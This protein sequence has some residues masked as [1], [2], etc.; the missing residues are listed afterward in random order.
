MAVTRFIT[1]GRGVRSGAVGSEGGG[2]EQSQAEPPQA[3]QPQ[4]PPTPTLTYVAG[5]NVSIGKRQF[6]LPIDRR[7]LMLF[8]DA[9]ESSR[10]VAAAVGFAFLTAFLFFHISKHFHDIALVVLC[11]I[12]ASAQYSL[13]RGVQPEPS[14]SSVDDPASSVTRGAF[15][16][17]YV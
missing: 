1:D 16:P 17:P 13:L 5:Y 2:A 4:P 3:E 7:T 8:L 15:F 11:F 14:S 6:C 12:V 9:H 10:R